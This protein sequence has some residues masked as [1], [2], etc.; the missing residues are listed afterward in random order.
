MELSHAAVRQAKKRGRDGWRQE[1]EEEE[2]FSPGLH[3]T[4]L[5][6]TE[7]I[8]LITALLQRYYSVITHVNHAGPEVRRTERSNLTTYS[9]FPSAF[10][11]RCD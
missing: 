3:R 8:L 11:W 5:V 4:S 7:L 9:E 10:P 1:E 6:P 2:E